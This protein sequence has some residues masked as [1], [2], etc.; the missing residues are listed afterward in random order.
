[1]HIAPIWFAMQRTAQT[2]LLMPALVILM[3]GCT[4]KQAS[5]VPPI[6]Q[7]PVAAIGTAI[8]NSIYDRR[9][10]QVKAHITQHYDALRDTILNHTMW[11]ALS[12][13]FMATCDMARVNTVN[14]SKLHHELRQDR[15]LYFPEQES[16]I[17]RTDTI[18]NLTIAFMVHGR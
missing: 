14:C 9:R 17:T 18:E 6:W 13:E 3:S 4:S 2:L 8:D 12:P 11:A 5:H 10:N 7:W 15:H 1:M 16:A